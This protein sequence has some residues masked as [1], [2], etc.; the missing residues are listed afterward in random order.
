MIQRLQHQNN[1]VKK[2]LDGWILQ[3]SQK[4][5]TENTFW[6]YFIIMCNLACYLVESTRLTFK[7]WHCCA[8]VYLASISFFLCFFSLSLSL[9]IWIVFFYLF[10]SNIRFI[11][12]FLQLHLSSFHSRN[13]RKFDYFVCFSS[14]YNYLFLFFAVKSKI[15]KIIIK[16]N[17]LF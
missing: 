2:L 8:F 5:D 3:T 16:S 15:I 17:P 10:Y 11:C 9:D 12:F 14:Q 1:K 13:F 7:H 6:K 4:Q